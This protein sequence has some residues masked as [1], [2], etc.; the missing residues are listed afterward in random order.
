MQLAVSTSTD[1]DMRARMRTYGR[2]D[3]SIIFRTIVDEIHGILGSLA[4]SSRYRFTSPGHIHNANSHR[5]LA[6]YVGI[7]RR[8]LACSVQRDGNSPLSKRDLFLNKQIAIM[9]LADALY[10]GMGFGV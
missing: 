1:A 3:H 2:V 4:Q 8:F 7:A 6:M 5:S 10:V 9:S